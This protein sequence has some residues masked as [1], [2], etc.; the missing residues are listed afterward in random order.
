MP[1]KVLRPTPL[2]PRAH[3]KLRADLNKI[4]WDVVY[5]PVVEA[6]RGILPK[7]AADKILPE[8]GDTRAELKNAGEETLRKAL[9]DGKVQVVRDRRHGLDV[10]FTAGA[11]GRELAD[12]IRDVGA[13]YD[14]VRKAYTMESAATPAWVTVESKAY[15]SRVRAT[16]DAIKETLDKIRA[17]LDEAL[18]KVNISKGARQAADEAEESWRTAARQLEMPLDMDEKSHAALVEAIK[19]SAKVP[20]KTELTRSIKELRDEVDEN[21]SRGYRAEGLAKRVR[22]RYG[23]SLAQADLIARQETSNLMATYQMERAKSAGLKRFV[24]RAVMD[25]RTRKLH[26]EF[27]GK[28]FSFDSPPFDPATGKPAIPGKTFRCRCVALPVIE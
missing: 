3:L 15:T 8:L 2:S 5:A 9:R 27:N 25:E 4:I 13:E 17:G 20:I 21:A 28:I 16:H 19:A 22:S 10:F 6:V 1:T 24:W 14:R 18:G 23:V 11:P 26:R 12:A 7:R